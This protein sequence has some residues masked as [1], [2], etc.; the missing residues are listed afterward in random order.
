MQ[1]N[2]DV[3]ISS[4]IGYGG[5]GIV[6]KAIY[7]GS[8]VAIKRIHLTDGIPFSSIRE[9]IAL[10]TLNHKNMI[11][12]KTYYI[13]KEDSEL[14]LNIILDYVS[15]T[16]LEY[17]ISNNV[18][19]D[20][21]NRIIYQIY[22]FIKYLNDNG[23]YHGDLSSK[24]C[25]ISKNNV[26]ITDFGCFNKIRR[27]S[28]Q[29]PVLEIT[30]FEVLEGEPIDNSKRDVWAM[31]CLYYLLLTN[32]ILMYG[33]SYDEYKDSILRMFNSTTITRDSFALQ[34]EYLSLIKM[35]V[36]PVKHN[37]Y[38]I[39][40]L[41][42]DTF[43]KK[44]TGP[45]IKFSNMKIKYYKKLHC[46]DIGI[47]AV[48]ND[49]IDKIS[50]SLCRHNTEPCH[51]ALRLA[52]G[53][54]DKV[55]SS[56][57]TICVLSYVVAVKITFEQDIQFTVIEQ[58]LDNIGEN[59]ITYDNYC[60]TCLNICQANNWCIDFD[61]PY[62]HVE[63][64][65]KFFNEID[66]L[67][68][69][70][71][72]VRSIEWFSTKEKIVALLLILYNVYDVDATVDCKICATSVTRCVK[73]YCNAINECNNVTSELSKYIEYRAKSSKFIASFIRKVDVNMVM[74]NHIKYLSM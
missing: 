35:M 17:V 25:M 63:L 1:P 74:K 48:M 11:P 18:K 58:L 49:I 57:R 65:G 29:L 15:S 16:V 13:S 34:H 54:I 2:D 27:S 71:E 10:H 42:K 51:I 59:S 40:K 44:V 8:I 31:G 20:D 32:D 39:D 7:K 41:S 52:L 43:F 56:V 30:P 22:N 28:T 72:I 64:I 68:Y 12:F 66:E 4:V 47:K 3:V 61:N 38:D 9:L 46:L 5:S 19:S 73:T 50:I 26:Y 23:Y 36:N 37:R 45:F 60:T 21:A 70:F 55:N 33:D 24:N 14:Y 62:D 69:T 53:S 6:Y 67:Y